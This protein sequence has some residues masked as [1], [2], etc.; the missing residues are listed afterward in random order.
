MGFVHSPGCLLPQLPSLLSP[1]LPAITVKIRAA[2]QRVNLT[3][4]HSAMRGPDVVDHTRPVRVSEEGADEAIGERDHQPISHV[5]H[6]FHGPL[7]A[8]CIALVN[9]P[10]HWDSST[11]LT[12]VGQADEGHSSAPF[13]FREESCD[14][15]PAIRGIGVHCPG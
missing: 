12:T 9:T 3:P 7:A 5:K 4:K 11:A 2:H 15:F 10:E 14:G 1:P 13:H 6:L 8:S